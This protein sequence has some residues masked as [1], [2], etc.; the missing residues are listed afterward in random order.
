MAPGVPS[1]AALWAKASFMACLTASKAHLERSFKSRRSRSMIPR[2]ALG[3]EK[4]QNRYG[5]ASRTSSVTFQA[6][7]SIRFC[8]HEGQSRV[9]QKKATNSSCLQEGQRIRAKPHS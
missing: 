9:F 7:R 3:I 4:V 5:T 8:S 1:P 6:K 2:I